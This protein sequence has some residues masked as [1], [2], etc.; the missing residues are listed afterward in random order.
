L[1]NCRGGLQLIDFLWARFPAK[2]L[3]SFGNGSRRDEDHL[4]SGSMQ[5]GNLRNPFGDQRVVDALTVVGDECGAN[6]DDETHWAL[7]IDKNKR[8]PISTGVFKQ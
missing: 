4:M 7:M 6:F 2:P 8:S 5:T 1:P 3:H